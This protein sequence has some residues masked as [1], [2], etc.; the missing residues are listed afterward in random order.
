M[1]SSSQI[2]TN[3]MP[4]HVISTF[5]GSDALPVAQPTV[6]EHWR[7]KQFIFLPHEVNSHDFRKY[8]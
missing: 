1:Q 5:C 4:L 8:F 3:N 7:E 6:S 2:V